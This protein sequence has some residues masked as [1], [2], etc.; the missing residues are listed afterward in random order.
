M[1]VCTYTI[2]A[3]QLSYV[4]INTYAYTVCVSLHSKHG[5]CEHKRTRCAAGITPGLVETQPVLDT[6][7]SCMN[8]RGPTV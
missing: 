5:F 2:V 8:T 3:S 4:C 1:Y 6:W 7:P